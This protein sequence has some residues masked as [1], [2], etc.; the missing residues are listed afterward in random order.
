MKTQT[1]KVFVDSISGNYCRLLISKETAPLDIP[2][3]LMPEG[4]SEGD[5]FSITIEP[6][7]GLRTKKTNDIKAILENLG[8]KI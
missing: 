8:N 1:K 6:L 5:W 3:E 4:T 7:T 2:L